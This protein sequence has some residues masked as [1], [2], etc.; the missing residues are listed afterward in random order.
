MSE[1]KLQ[2]LQDSGLVDWAV[3]SEIV[4]MDEDEE[5]FSN[6]LVEVFVSQVE[7]TFEEIDK[8]LKEKNLEK[9]SS[10]GHFLKGSAAAL[11][12]TKISNQCE[13]IQ[14]YGHKINFDNFQLE[15]IKTKGDSAVS[16]ENVAVNDGETN[17][18]NGS[19]GNETSNKKT[20]TINIP[21]ESSDDF[22]IALIEDALA[23]ARD[24]FD[25]SRRALD[26]YYE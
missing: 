1:D 25:Q 14:N 13:R 19:N 6:S 8:Y 16:A 20:N 24:G 11:G 21:D 9:L 26:E 10:S 12:L 18:E 17:P 15:D 2:K 3:F 7:E 5:G 4:T 22:W 23:K